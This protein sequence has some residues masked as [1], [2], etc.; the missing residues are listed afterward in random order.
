MHREGRGTTAHFGATSE[1]DFIMGTFSKAF[2]SIGGFIASDDDDALECLQHQSRPLIFSAALPV[3]SV[4]AALASINVLEKEPERLE[5]LHE[6]ARQ[7]R[8]GFR[9]IGLPVLDGQTPIVPIFV[10]SELKAAHLAKLLFEQG[11]FALPA[12]YPAVPKGKA[13]IR[14]AFMA[15]HEKRQIDFVLETFCRLSKEFLGQTEEPG[16]PECSNTSAGSIS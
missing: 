12:V 2:A 9:E 13:V 11:I 5:R 15:T 3:S 1:V 16:S 14:T 6:N 4:A 7:A 10:G 8:A